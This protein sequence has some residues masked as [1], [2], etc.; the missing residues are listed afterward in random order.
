MRIPSP[1]SVVFYLWC[2]VGVYGWKQVFIQSDILDVA[3][4]MRDH[5]DAVPD[6]LQHIDAIDPRMQCDEEGWLVKNP[7]GIRTEREIH[8]E[9]EGAKIYRRLYQKLVW[10]SSQFCVSVFIYSSAHQ[11]RLRVFLFVC[12]KCVQRHS[13]LKFSQQTNTS[14]MTKFGRDVGTKFCYVTWGLVG[15]GLSRPNLIWILCQFMKPTI[16]LNYFSKLSIIS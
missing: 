4:D 2:I 12:W 10:D 6:L 9:L 13:N 7:M 5:F 8:A 14:K 16:F 1:A 3:V 15:A 11:S